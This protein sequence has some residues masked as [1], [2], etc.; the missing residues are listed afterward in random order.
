MNRN[1]AICHF[2]LALATRNCEPVS[3]PENTV[4]LNGEEH[5]QPLGAQGS[6]LLLRLNLPLLKGKK[7]SL[8]LSNFSR[9]SLL[10]SCYLTLCFPRNHVTDIRFPQ[11]GALHTQPNGIR[12]PTAPYSQGGGSS[13]VCCAEES[14]Q[15]TQHSAFVL[16][17]QG[18]SCL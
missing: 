14:L 11:Q 15:P 6:N 2:S 9:Y 7:V 13:L 10:V 8:I 4:E 1:A 12:C 18:M 16:S 5:I 3:I 17:M